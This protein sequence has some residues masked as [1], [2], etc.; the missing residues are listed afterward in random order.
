MLK[1]KQLSVVWS[2]LGRDDDD[3]L[4]YGLWMTFI[5]LIRKTEAGEYKNLSINI[6]PE[7]VKVERRKHEI[8]L[9]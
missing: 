2:V 8:L 7:S 4:G 1:R 3:G 5:V 9:I 6:G